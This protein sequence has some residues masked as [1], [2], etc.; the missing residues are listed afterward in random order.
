IFEPLPDFIDTSFLRVFNPAFF[1]PNTPT[2]AETLARDLRR[3]SL[4]PAPS[5]DDMDDEDGIFDECEDN[6]DCPDGSVCYGGTCHHPDL[7]QETDGLEGNE[8]Y[9]NPFHRDSVV[10]VK[11]QDSSPDQCVCFWFNSREGPVYSAHECSGQA[12]HVREFSCNSG[13]EVYECENGCSEGACISGGEDLIAKISSDALC[14]AETD[15]DLSFIEVEAVEEVEDEEPLVEEVEVF[16]LVAVSEDEEVTGEDRCSGFDDNDGEILITKE[17]R[18]DCRKINNENP[19]KILVDPETEEEKISEGHCWQTKEKSFCFQKGRGVK[20]LINIMINSD[21]LAART[22]AA[23][24]LSL[25][26]DLRAIQP[27]FRVLI[28][29]EENLDVRNN[30]AV[31]L[32]VTGKPATSSLIRALHIING[33]SFVDLDLLERVG[34]SLY[35]SSSTGREYLRGLLK[36][37]EDHIVKMAGIILA[38]NKDDSAVKPLIKHF[39][40]EFGKTREVIAYTL[41]VNFEEHP[42]IISNLK[43]L[44]SWAPALEPTQTL[45]LMRNI[46]SFEDIYN[47]DSIK[48]LKGYERNSV[49]FAVYRFLKDNFQDLDKTI[50]IP[51]VSLNYAVNLILDKRE[52]FRGKVI[53]G[54]DTYLIHFTHEA[55]E[56][57]K[58]KFSNER[59]ENFAKSRGITKIA[60]TNLKGPNSKNKIREI[61]R[62]SKDKGETTIWF[63]G[64][65]G[66]TSLGLGYGAD[67]VEGSSESKPGLIFFEDLGDDLSKRGKLS[68]VTILIDACFSYNFAE[69]LIDYLKNKKRVN[70][71]PTIITETNKDRYG[72][73]DRFIES[74]ESLNL[75][76]KLPLLGEHIYESERTSL[77]RQ[78]SAVFFAEEGKIPLEVAEN[79]LYHGCPVC[80]GGVC[81]IEIGWGLDPGDDFET[82][83]TSVVLDIENKNY[84]KLKEGFNFGEVTGNFVSFWEEITGRVTDD[85]TLAEVCRLP[86]EDSSYQ[87]YSD[88]L[89]RNMRKNKM[90]RTMDNFERVLSHIEENP[91]RYGSW[92]IGKL[93][94]GIY[95]HVSLTLDEVIRRIS[96]NAYRNQPIFFIEEGQEGSWETGSIFTMS[97]DFPI[98]TTWDYRYLPDYRQKRRLLTSD[99]ILGI[100]PRW[101]REKKGIMEFVNSEG[102]IVNLKGVDQNLESSSI[103]D[104]LLE[105]LN[106]A[107]FG[108][109]M[110]PHFKAAAYKV[111]IL[112]H[113]NYDFQ[114]TYDFIK[115]SDTIEILRLLD[116]IV[117]DD[118]IMAFGGMDL[119]DRIFRE[120]NQRFGCNLELKKEGDFEFYNTYT[121][122]D[123]DQR[124]RSV[125][126]NIESGTLQKAIDHFRSEEFQIILKEKLDNIASID[127]NEEGGVVLGDPLNLEEDLGS[128]DPEK[129]SLG[130]RA[131]KLFKQ[132]V[133]VGDQREFCKKI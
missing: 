10:F 82:I 24:D 40:D 110:I 87:D 73:G 121:A 83:T 86:S 119:L 38:M 102:E 90:P 113:F 31:A 96:S 114:K 67:F 44:L 126:N 111:L 89:F 97:G 115:T 35:R 79:T 133:N 104:Y 76:E 25:I 34:K 72:Y 132:A 6:S 61:I 84:N 101:I 103:C 124:V 117:P 99:P 5:I 45:K 23:A 9:N 92:E 51:S 7:C 49:S 11:G 59:M 56:H 60:D 131:V 129:P 12:T 36:S 118:D 29:D 13:T 54:R 63:N 85:E 128:C 42:L 64:H 93:R 122:L 125:L 70:E 41:L 30:A 98:P 95:S 109:S 62:E 18:V 20:E 91:D 28:N 80:E 22:N 94:R 17:G 71:F 53:L 8:G 27:L 75:Q 58:L 112:D 14:G 65:G 39:D 2:R 33:Q 16:K 107:P 77:T 74:L 21:D 55:E 108:F 81:P 1:D 48:I 37:D 130:K 127:L 116:Q 3:D 19:P 47:H 120:L 46:P 15:V 105:D 69:S 43:E 66:K 100:L 106:K 78:D 50:N 4:D 123:I 52:K 57:P 68:E 32:G 88:S 26:K